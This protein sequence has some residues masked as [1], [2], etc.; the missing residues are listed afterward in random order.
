MRKKGWHSHQAPASAMMTMDNTS[1]PNVDCFVWVCCWKLNTLQI[2]RM[3]SNHIMS[4]TL[5]VIFGSLVYDK[6]LCY[7]LINT[8]YRRAC[9]AHIWCYLHNITAQMCVVLDKTHM[10]VTSKASTMN[11]LAYCF[12]TL[13]SIWSSLTQLGQ[14]L[15]PHM[16]MSSGWRAVSLS[17]GIW[18]WAAIPPHQ[19]EPI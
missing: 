17:M 5:C 3:F 18:D 6:H 19:K 2:A 7:R 10:I 4:M 16:V 13:R 9:F 11:Q 8:I 14:Y 15:R 12:S 1:C